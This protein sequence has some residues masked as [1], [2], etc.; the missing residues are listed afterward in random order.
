MYD[1]KKYAPV[2][3]EPLRSWVFAEAA[4]AQLRLQRL[5]ILTKK[6][7]E[8]HG[9]IALCLW[10]LANGANLP[11]GRSATQP[12]LYSAIAIHEKVT[13]SRIQFRL[14]SL[15]EGKLYGRFFFSK[16]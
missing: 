13:T 8:L 3:W 4:E 15:V 1:N 16:F 5:T 6:D 14:I 11:W 7:V 2:A 9:I 12:A 10:K